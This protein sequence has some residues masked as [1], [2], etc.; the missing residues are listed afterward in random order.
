MWPRAVLHFHPSAKSVLRRWVSSEVAAIS[1]EQQNR[2]F[3]QERERQANLI[4]RIEKIQVTVTNVKP[5]PEEEVV[6]LMNK[7]IST[8]YNCAQHISEL[9]V[10]RSVVADIDGRLVDMHSPLHESCKLRL[11]HFYEEDVKLVNKVYWRSCSF[12][13]GWCVATA[14]RADQQVNLHSFPTPNPNLGS[15][16]YDVKL[17]HLSDWKPNEDELFALN[18]HI[19]RATKEQEKR[20]ERLVVP[21]ALALEIMKPNQYKSQQI[22]SMASDEITLYRLDNH[23]DVSVGPMIP[24]TSFVGT[25]DIV[26]VHQIESPSAGKLY[27]FQGTSIPEQLRMNHFAYKQLVLSAAKLNPSSPVQ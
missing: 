14:F 22:A 27:R 6:L 23:I 11:R 4:S 24:D 17:P 7:S 15:F 18:T 1:R 21:K 12:L 19:R 16:V 8:P 10:N 25:I 9:F 2:L 13:L 20:F 5:G 3:D 26:A